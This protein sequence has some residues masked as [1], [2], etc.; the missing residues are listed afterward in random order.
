MHDCTSLPSVYLQTWAFLLIRA[1]RMVLFV[2]RV[3][4][5]LAYMRSLG[6][7]IFQLIMGRKQYCVG[8]SCRKSN[9]GYTSQDSLISCCKWRVH[10]RCTKMLQQ[11]TSTTVQYYLLTGSRTLIEAIYHQ[12]S[13]DQITDLQ[14]THMFIYCMRSASSSRHVEYRD[15]SHHHSK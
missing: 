15:V 9:I 1:Q 10:G 7:S 2:L 3:G 8:R 12:R 13:A 5:G 6:S 14:P 11:R 4:S